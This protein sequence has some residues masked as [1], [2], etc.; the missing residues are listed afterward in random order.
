[1][2]T[3]FYTKVYHLRLKQTRLRE[4]WHKNCQNKRST[5]TVYYA[6]G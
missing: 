6:R 3:H 2:T 5:I 1:M 4:E